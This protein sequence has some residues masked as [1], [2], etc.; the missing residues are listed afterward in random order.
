MKITI[1]NNDH[2]YTGKFGF[3]AQ[4]IVMTLAT[5]LAAYLLPGVHIS[6]LWSAILTALVIALLNNFIR[7][8]L[9]VLT[10]PF[11]L[12]SMGLFLLFINA[13]IIMLASGLVP[14]FKVD[15]FWSALLFSL[16]LT[17]LNYLLELP[18]KWMN[19]K[20]FEEEDNP[21]SNN[22]YHSIS[23]N[24]NIEYTDYEEVDDNSTE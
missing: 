5:I 16:L 17:L 6:N 21:D 2:L 23:D 9:I 15:G 10:L 19:R 18:H 12:F 7:P 13:F 14:D 24:E 1:S 20:T 3:V 4:G 22:T 11:T 8:I